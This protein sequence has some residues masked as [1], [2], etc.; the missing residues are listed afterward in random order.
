MDSLFRLI[1]VEDEDDIRNGLTKII[2][3]NE[4]GFVVKDTFS[5]GEDAK[6][7]LTEND[8]DIVITDICLV[9]ISGLELAEWININ[10]PSIKI[11]ILSGHSDFKYAQLAINFNVYKYFL[12]PIDIGEFKLIFNKLY[13]DLKKTVQT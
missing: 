7:Y 8:V 6:R 4:M 2:N 3:W 5:N 9:G 13:H 1:I 10:K 11:L 12:K